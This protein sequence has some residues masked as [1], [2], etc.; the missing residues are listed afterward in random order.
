MFRLTIGLGAVT[1]ISGSCVGGGAAV[2]CDIA[3]PPNPHSN[4]QLALPVLR[5]RLAIDVIVPF[6]KSL[7]RIRHR[8]R[9]RKLAAVDMRRTDFDRSRGNRPRMAIPLRGDRSID[10]RR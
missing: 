8:Q 1:V 6:L 10:V 9:I 3:L 5:T 7:G 2:S 4:S